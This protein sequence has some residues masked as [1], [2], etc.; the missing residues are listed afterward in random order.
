VLLLSCFVFSCVYFIRK[1]VLHVCVCVCVCFCL[2][3]HE[4]SLAGGGRE[5]EVQK[6]FLKRVLCLKIEFFWYMIVCRLLRYLPTFRNVPR[7]RQLQRDV[8]NLLQID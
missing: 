2:R 7:Y 3:A 8:E 4:T 5:L 6:T 1:N